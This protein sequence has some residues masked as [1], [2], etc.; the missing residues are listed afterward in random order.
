L[1]QECDLEGLPDL[2]ELLKG[3]N[4]ARPEDRA[5]LLA[6]S[7]SVDAQ[8]RA[9]RSFARIHDSERF[10]DP[11]AFPNLWARDLESLCQVEL[12]GERRS[13]GQVGGAHL[14][15]KPDVHGGFSRP[16]ATQPV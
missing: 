6:P 16:V 10:Q 7:P 15:Q 2:Q 4:A 1:R 8:P 3:P 13:H 5:Q 12:A 14:L 9:T 11:E